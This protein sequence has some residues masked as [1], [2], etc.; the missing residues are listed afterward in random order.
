MV[1]PL[2]HARAFWKPLVSEGEL[3]GAGWL[4]RSWR[5][6]EPEASTCG[7]LIQSRLSTGWFTEPASSHSSPRFSRS[8]THRTRRRSLAEIRDLSGNH[9]SFVLWFADE[10]CAVI[11]FDPNAA[12]EALRFEQY[13]P[14]AR[15]TVLPSP[16]LS[17]YYSV[18]PLIPAWMRGQLRRAVAAR[19]DE[20][21][22]FLSWPSDQSL[23]HLM[24][25]VLRLMLMTMGRD[26]LPFVWFWPEQHPWAAILTHDVETAAGLAH[27]PEV[28]ELET[29]RGLR[30]SFNLVP[31]DY[32]VRGSDLRETAR[33]RIRGR[34][35]WIHA[36]WPHVRPV[37]DISEA[38]RCSQRD[39]TP[40]GGYGISVAGDLPEPRVV[41]PAWIRI[42]L[43][44]D[45]HRSV[46]ATT[47][48]VRFRFP[49]YGRPTGRTADDPP[50]RPH[51]LQPAE[52]R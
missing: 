43:L 23:D 1:D 26:T 19:A 31:Y 22:A 21:E 10:Q 32:E 36:R 6:V 38:G 20:S 40:V 13:V 4:P 11:P 2:H 39:W 45:R 14:D 47:G 27:V 24:Q 7:G 42:R 41:P 46:R 12:I 3:E 34:R 25:L 37:V 8:T 50:A 17:A 33:R 44:S 5:H 51:S 9:H 15:R 16:V 52:A 29:R 28:M 18:K 35:A 48:R 30:S 49:L